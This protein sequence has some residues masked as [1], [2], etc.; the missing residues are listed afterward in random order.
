MIKCPECKHDVYGG[1]FWLTG[2][3]GAM[4]ECECGHKFPEPP[5]VRKPNKRIAEL[6]RTLAAQRTA[7]LALADEMERT[8]R[9]GD[10]GRIREIVKP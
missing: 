8:G 10:A 6:E 1:R 5:R 2:I 4:R 9:Q 7:L 3:K